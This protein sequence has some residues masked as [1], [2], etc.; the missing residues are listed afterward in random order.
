MSPD[1]RPD[2]FNEADANAPNPVVEALAIWRETWQATPLERWNRLNLWSTMRDAARARRLLAEIDERAFCRGALEEVG[3][4][5]KKRRDLTAELAADA[6]LVARLDDLI[7]ASA[8]SETAPTL[9]ELFAV[10]NLP[11]SDETPDGDVSD[12]TGG[13]SE[14]DENAE[15]SPQSRANSEILYG[16]AGVGRSFTDESGAIPQ[17]QARPLEPGDVVVLSDDYEIK[18]IAGKGGQKAVYEVVSKRLGTRF[19]VKEL[20]SEFGGSEA[21]RRDLEREVKIQAR[22]QHQGIP[23]VFALTPD[24]DPT[25]DGLPRFV[26]TYVEGEPWSA[27]PFDRAHFEENLDYLL[28][29]AKIMAYAHDQGVVH[30]DLKPENVML[31]RYGELYVVDWGLAFD[32][33]AEGPKTGAVGTQEYMAPEQASRRPV[34]KRADVFTLG[35][36]LYKILTGFA[37]YELAQRTQ[38]NAVAGRK[39]AACDFAPLDPEAAKAEFLKL[40]EETLTSPDAAPE[41]R[42]FAEK[43][44]YVVASPSEILTFAEKGL[45][46]L[47]ASNPQCEN[48][49][50]FQGNV[51]VGLFYN[52]CFVDVFGNE[53]GAASPSLNS[54]PAPP[55]RNDAEELQ[56]IAAKALLSVDASDELRR[57]AELALTASTFVSPK[58]RDIIAAALASNPNERFPDATAFVKA[59]ETYRPQNDTLEHFGELKARFNNVKHILNQE[60]NSVTKTALEPW[61]DQGTQL[62][63]EFTELRLLTSS[64]IYLAPNTNRQLLQEL[65][66][67]EIAARYYLV[68]KALRL[69]K[70]EFTQRL[71]QEQRDVIQEY[72]D[73]Q[74]D[75]SEKTAVLKTLQK[76]AQKIERIARDKKALIRGGKIIIAIFILYALHAAA[77][78]GAPG[79]LV[80]GFGLVTLLVIAAIIWLFVIV[81]IGLAFGFDSYGKQKKF[82]D[83]SSRL[84]AKVTETLTQNAKL[85]RENERLRRELA[86]RG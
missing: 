3:F 39:A 42:A 74:L 46:K 75:A 26:E 19:A 71:I 68:D 73:A 82:Q 51:C 41:L 33:K 58:L 18:R 44:V 79:I 69:K 45:V 47:D 55:S 35:G 22:L 85:R 57:L 80:F 27:R 60:I 78:R 61:L 65:Y 63:T 34:D 5:A 72:V 70:I 28:Q 81:M 1:R 56:K 50:K 36:I 8:A 17:S 2:D 66:Q 30:R 10:W 64:N 11:T 32:W 54:K 49:A 14:R 29:V 48:A 86:D 13:D 31:G 9:A 40:A 7:D 62:L 77:L 23:K 83:E 21:L 52:S 43:A 59:L 67:F 20:L 12:A 4:E 37:P 6:E 15:P 76:T 24:A 84:N 25:S 38:G 53:V 16:G